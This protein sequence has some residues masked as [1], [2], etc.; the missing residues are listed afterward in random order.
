MPT[1]TNR[2]YSVPTTG[3]QAGIWGSD[4][5]NPNFVAID[6]NLGAVSTVALSSVDVTLNS[7][8]YVCGTIK[9][10]GT[11]TANVTVTFPTVSGWWT[12]INA[13]T[14]NFYIRLSCSSGGLKICPPPGEATNIGF[15]GTDAFYKSL[16]H[17]V[18]SYWD[19]AGA[20]VPVWVSGC[21]VPPYLHCNAGTFSQV[22]YP[23]LFSILGTTS[24]PDSRGCTR[25]ALNSGTGR[26]TAGASGINGD[27]RFSIGGGQVI[28]LTDTTVPRTHV[29][30]E[31]F[32]LGHNHPASTNATSRDENAPGILASPAAGRYTGGSPTVT[33]GT[34]YA[35]IIA[36]GFV[37]GLGG[38]HINMQPS[39]V[40]GITM[41][42]AA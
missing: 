14:G 18:G 27:A 1:T 40:G 2:G 34:G 8:Q 3:S 12:V 16:P 6:Q 41:I 37:D 11:L 24:L 31:A 38:A 36:G 35:Q 42:R 22:T 39:Y 10:T 4:D 25:I 5:L 20:S 26:V 9:F 30:V 33:I 13:C 28:T 19:Y 23:Y 21:S 17:L 15:D 32:D 29:S 7:S